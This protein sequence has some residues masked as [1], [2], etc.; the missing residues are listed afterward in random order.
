NEGTAA[1][2]GCTI[3]GNFGR[4]GGGVYNT[5]TATFTNCT[6]SG[7]AADATGHGGGLANHGTATLINCTV[8]LN[9]VGS[10]GGGGVW[11]SGTLNIGNTIV[12][13][14]ELDTKGAF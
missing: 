9:A 1:L 2:S 4:S 7:N 3:S 11:T 8:T 10:D 5:G 6:V 14:N 13:G 12:S